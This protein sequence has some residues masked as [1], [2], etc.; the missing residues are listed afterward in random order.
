[1]RRTWSTIVIQVRR[2]FARSSTH[3]HPSR[4]LGPEPSSLAIPA[5]LEEAETMPIIASDG[6]VRQNFDRGTFAWVLASA[7][8]GTPAPCWLKCKGP[9]RGLQVNSF[10]AEGYGLLSTLLYLNLLAEH[11]HATIPMI[12]IH[13]DNESFLTR[14]ANQEIDNDLLSQMKHYLQV[15]TDSASWCIQSLLTDPR[16]DDNDLFHNTNP[17]SPP[18][19][20]IDTISD[21]NT[22]EAYVKSYQQYINGIIQGKLMAK[23]YEGVLLLIATILRSTSGSICVCHS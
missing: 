7:A 1:M 3:H 21:I 15:G 18:P 13:T 14:I 19:T 20:T 12:D 23:E 9:V 8:D 11:V 17:L 4:Q 6:S 22:S 2:S 16:T 5:L 10:R